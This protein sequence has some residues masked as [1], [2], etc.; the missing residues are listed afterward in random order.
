MPE[1]S[2]RTRR[3]QASSP[4]VLPSAEEHAIHA[5]RGAAR[6]ARFEPTRAA[7]DSHRY[8]LTR[9][10]KSRAANA[11]LWCLRRPRPR[12]ADCPSD[13][14]RPRYHRAFQ[15]TPPYRPRRPPWRHEL[16]TANLTVWTHSQGVF[17]LG[18]SRPSQRAHLAMSPAERSVCIHMECAGFYWPH[19]ARTTAAFRCRPPRARAE[20]RKAGVR[21]AVDARRRVSWWG[22]RALGG[23]SMRWAPDS[24]P[25]GNILR[26]APTSV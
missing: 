2:S 1:S 15:C 23:M 6:A 21:V 17:R 11:Y 20:P 7:A 22:N 9:P 13:I 5:P 14:S 25:D 12:R 26:L 4:V 24:A 18:A 19:T 8:L 16:W 10:P 3:A